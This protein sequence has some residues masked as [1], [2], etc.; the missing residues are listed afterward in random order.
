MSEPKRYALINSN[1][2]RPFN[3]DFIKIS[4]SEKNLEIKN[5]MKQLEKLIKFSR[6]LFLNLSF[7]FR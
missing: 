2:K 7:F 6:P 5:A 4:I 3:S 1:F